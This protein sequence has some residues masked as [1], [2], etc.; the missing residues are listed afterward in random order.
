MVGRASGGVEAVGE[1]WREELWKNKCETVAI[2]VDTAA[3][4]S[5]SRLMPG[6]LIELRTGFQGNHAR[7]FLPVLKEVIMCL[8]KLW[9]LR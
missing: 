6:H 7:V 4:I 8:I 9:G 5:L 1:T 2:S 3:S